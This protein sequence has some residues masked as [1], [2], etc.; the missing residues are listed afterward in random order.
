MHWK[1]KL[2]PGRE[3]KAK[4]LNGARSLHDWHRALKFAIAG[5][6]A[7]QKTLDS[8]LDVMQETP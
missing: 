5:V 4:W 7:G 6:M 3:R 1:E 8:A 2:V